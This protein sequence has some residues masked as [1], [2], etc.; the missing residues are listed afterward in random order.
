MDGLQF[1]SP[2]KVLKWGVKQACV[3]VN[4]VL[5]PKQ[6]QQYLA[7]AD[8]PRLHFGCSARV[9][10]GWLNSDINILPGTGRVLLDSTQLPWAIPDNSLDFIYLHHVLEHMPYMMARDTF[11]EFF[12]ILKP[13]GI[14]RC[15]VPDMELYIKGY[16]HHQKNPDD[17]G[18]EEFLTKDHAHPSTQDMLNGV[19]NHPVAAI[20]AVFYGHG[21]VFMYDETV[22][23]THFDSVGFTN[24]VRRNT[25]EYGDPI[26]DLGH[27][28]PVDPK[29]RWDI[30]LILEATKSAD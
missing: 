27:E 26:F 12:R 23:R 3:P 28:H 6:I 30:N 1:S 22:L 2:V 7:T 9:E 18:L 11:G 8:K 20:N 17:K 19:P 24:V 21:H 15:V 29:V 5:A 14:I 25:T 10:K 4:K 16:L 13:G